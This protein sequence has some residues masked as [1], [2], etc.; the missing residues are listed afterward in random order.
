M[1]HTHSNLRKFDAHFYNES[2][3]SNLFIVYFYLTICDVLIKA[4]LWVKYCF[5]LD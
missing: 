4:L 2:L 3:E 1:P 5:L